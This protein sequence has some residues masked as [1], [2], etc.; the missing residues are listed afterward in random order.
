MDPHG[1]QRLPD[2]TVF[3]QN[4]GNIYRRRKKNE[5]AENGHKKIP[6]CNRIAVA[7]ASTRFRPMTKDYFMG[8][9]CWCSSERG[10]RWCSS[11]AMSSK[12]RQSRATSYVYYSYGTSDRE[13]LRSNTYGSHLPRGD[14]GSFHYGLVHK[15]ST[16]QEAMR[17][18]DAQARANKKRET[19]K[20]IPALDENKVKT[21]TD[22]IQ[23][24]TN[25][26]QS[27]SKT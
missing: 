23:R 15:P 1:S 20:R 11:D 14:V 7:V 3:R 25:K 4:R 6:K 17:I 2:Q 13:N 26:K 24:A 9:D 27:T 5:F 12:D 21:K 8:I 16:V 18:L 10:R 19:W 22:V